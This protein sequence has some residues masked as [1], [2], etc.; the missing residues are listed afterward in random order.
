MKEEVGLDIYIYIYLKLPLDKS[1]KNEAVLV[2]HD[3]WKDSIEAALL[4]EVKI[5]RRSPRTA[6]RTRKQKQK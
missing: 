2:V 3:L 5:V 6:A 1:W 4:A